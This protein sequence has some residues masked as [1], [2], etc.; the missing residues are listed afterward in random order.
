MLRENFE[1]GYMDAGFHAL[2]LHAHHYAE[3]LI[4]KQGATPLDDPGKTLEE[5][6]TASK[7]LEVWASE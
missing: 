5:A 2:L 6:I 3:Q 4:A 1:R 7:I